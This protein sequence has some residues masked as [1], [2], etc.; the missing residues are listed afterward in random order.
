MECNNNTTTAGECPQWQTCIDHSKIA[1]EPTSLMMGS[2]HKMTLSLATNAH[3]N[4]SDIECNLRNLSTDITLSIQCHHSYETNTISCSNDTE[5]RNT[6]VECPRDGDCFINCTTSYH[7][8]SIDCSACYQSI[9]ICPEARGCAVICQGHYSCAN[10]IFYGAISHVTCVGDHACAFSGFYYNSHRHNKDVLHVCEGENACFSAQFVPHEEASLNV[11]CHKTSCVYTAFY[12]LSS[13]V[14]CNVTCRSDGCHHCSFYVYVGSEIYLTI[15]NLEESEIITYDS[16]AIDYPILRVHSSTHGNHLEEYL[17]LQPVNISA[18]V[19]KANCTIWVMGPT[20]DVLPI[21]IASTDPLDLYTQYSLFYPWIAFSIILFLYIVI[22]IGIFSK[23]NKYYWAP[24]MVVFHFLSNISWIYFAVFCALIDEV[25]GWALL[26]LII[27]VWVSK[28]ITLASIGPGRRIRYHRSWILLLICSVCADYCSTLL[29]LK[30]KLFGTPVSLRDIRNLLGFRAKRSRLIRSRCLDIYFRSGVLIAIPWLYQSYV[31]VNVFSAASSAYFC[32]VVAVIYDFI[33]TAIMYRSHRWKNHIAIEMKLQLFGHDED[34]QLNIFDSKM[35]DYEGAMTKQ[36]QSYVPT[37]NCIVEVV[38]VGTTDQ[39]NEVDLSLSV[40]WDSDTSKLDI[41]NYLEE[42]LSDFKYSNALKTFL[43]SSQNA[44]LKRL[45]VVIEGDATTDEMREYLI[46]K[47]YEPILKECQYTIEEPIAL[48]NMNRKHII[49]LVSYYILNDNKYKLHSAHVMGLIQEAH[50]DGAAMTEQ[51]EKGVDIEQY[52]DNILGGYINREILSKIA[53]NITQD[54]AR[55]EMNTQSIFHTICMFAIENLKAEWRSKQIIDGQ[56]IIEHMNG[57]QF[58]DELRSVTAL[59]RDDCLQIH[60]SVVQYYVKS[61]E[62]QIMDRVEQIFTNYDN[63]ENVRSRDKTDNKLN[64]KQTETCQRKHV[65]KQFR[66]PEAGYGCDECESNGFPKL[67]IMFRCRVCGYAICRSCLNASDNS[68]SSGHTP[69]CP[70]K[71]GLK[72]FRTPSAKWWCDGCTAISGNKSQLA[73]ETIMFGC[74]TCKYDLCDSCF[75]GDDKVDL[76]NQIN[77]E[78]LAVKLKNNVPIHQESAMLLNFIENR[79][80]RTSEKMVNRILMEVAGVFC[81]LCLD[82]WWCSECLYHNRIIKINGKMLT[83]NH[84]LMHNCIVCGCEKVLSIFNT[85]KGETKTNVFISDTIFQSKMND[86]LKCKLYDKEDIALCTHYRRMIDFLKSNSESEIQFLDYVDALE[87]LTH[88]EL[89]NDILLPSIDHMD[90]HEVIDAS[91]LRTLFKDDLDEKESL[92][93]DGQ[94]LL[95]LTQSALHDIIMNCDGDDHPLFDG[96]KNEKEP[97]NDSKMKHPSARC[98]PSLYQSILKQ[99]DVFISQKQRKLV[100]ASY[101]EI[102][103]AWN[104]LMESHDIH[105]IFGDDFACNDA[106]CDTASRR[107]QRREKRGRSMSRK[108]RFADDCAFSEHTKTQILIYDHYKHD[109]DSIHYG[110][111]HTNRDRV[112]L[113]SVQNEEQH[114]VDI[115]DEENEL[116]EAS[117]PTTTVIYAMSD[118]DDDDIEDGSRYNTNIGLYGFGVDHQ[119]P[120]LKP[121]RFC[122]RDELLYNTMH[123]LNVNIFWRLLAKAL[124]KHRVA[125]NLDDYRRKLA[126]KY[127]SKEFNLIRNQ[128][129]GIRHVLALVIYTDLTKFCTEFRKTYRRIDDEISDDQVIKRH[130]QIYYYARGLYEAIEFYG[131]QMKPTDEV[132]HGLNRVMFFQKFTAY[133][134]QPMSTTP[135]KTIAH[136]FAQS[137]GAGIILTLKSGTELETKVSKI[138]KYLGVAWLSDYPTEEEL[139]YYGNNVLFK[140]YDIYETNGNASH[141]KALSAL[142]DFQNIVQN[143]CVNLRKD[144]IDILCDFI[145]SKEKTEP[146]AIDS[147][148]NNGTYIQRLFAYFCNHPNTTSI[149]I[150]NYNHLPT[151]FKT[152]LLLQQSEE[153]KENDKG[154]ASS[155]KKGKAKASAP[156]TFIHLVNLFSRLREIMFTNLRMDQMV[157]QS[158][159]YMNAVVEYIG[160]SHP[161]TYLIKVIFQSERQHD[162]KEHS[163][164]KRLLV[165]KNM[166]KLENHRWTINY[167]FDLTNTLTHCLTFLNKQPIDIPTKQPSKPSKEEQ[168][169]VV[170]DSHSI[171]KI[172]PWDAYPEYLLQILSVDAEEIQIKLTL[173]EASKLKLNCMVQI[174]DGNNRTQSQRFTVHPE[175]FCGAKDVEVKPNTEYKLAIFLNDKQISNEVSTQTPM[176]HFD[177]KDGYVP[178]APSVDSIRKYYDKNEEHVLF[179]W[180]Y[181]KLVLGDRIIYQIKRSDHS[182]N[183]EIDALPYTISAMDLSDCEIQIR[184]KSIIDGKQFE[185][186]WLVVHTAS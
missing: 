24:I 35:I 101:A 40:E 132:Y 147:E 111:L 150:H 159:T 158:G 51:I 162:R 157:H 59:D 176:A 55:S 56:W 143:R 45:K 29:L 112:P 46:N 99:I 152:Q 109:L 136:Q 54:D 76:N 4:T 15:S 146:N 168:K 37:S 104:H 117:L 79:L 120:H 98:I 9:F 16:H 129:I 135:S 177:R 22:V 82:D 138:P 185:G 96:D 85:L 12:C 53:I 186:K 174:T 156:L 123:A 77:F 43:N 100:G 48:K 115:Q 140:I 169:V 84:D 81:D 121:T 107:S 38:N 21:W 154:D 153:L 102:V 52:L 62:D 86:D 31:F 33:I 90:R 23:G 75:N 160:Y 19:C 3:L 124:N 2:I 137:E 118:S 47:L 72:Q 39:K 11:I 110:L 30:I 26:V 130:E 73:E 89:I 25:Y 161:N 178:S 122:M 126:C 57:D 42:T 44:S 78:E 94:F 166:A 149:A 172:E 70:G 116:K 106:N 28:L 184:T 36:I 49:D 27:I 64:K 163:A 60:R 91:K 127:Y 179:I 134:N 17:R 171:E 148:H 50:I 63:V 7:C 67:V 95:R 66:T 1:I 13:A 155:R 170:D 93:D 173:K 34:A 133:F 97:L 175:A 119:H 182:Q 108:R 71:H 139:L 92:F 181:P 180:D 125:A 61:S 88:E 165:K 8:S 74:R 128:S 68:Q 5:C 41:Q 58:V 164:L 167:H 131:N 14:V 65:W 144:V 87:N 113:I 142:N 151:K 32:M 10:T 18:D 183:E 80:Q 6:T 69:N 103:F 141:Q 83:P 20:K 105:Q 114:S 145:K